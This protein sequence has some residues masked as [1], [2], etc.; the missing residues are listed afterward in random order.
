V[1]AATVAGVA[2]LATRIPHLEFE[3]STENLL[4]D[5]TATPALLVRVTRRR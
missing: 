1:I 3:T 2:G 5:I 4:R